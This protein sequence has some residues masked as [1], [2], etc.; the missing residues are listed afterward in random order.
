MKKERI[1]KIAILSAVFVIA[2][3]ISSYFV[4]RGNAG[5]ATDMSVA[6]LPTVSFDMNGHKVNELVG[7]KQEMSVA[8]VRDNIL[9]LGEKG[10]ITMNINHLEQKVVDVTYEVFSLDGKEEILK[11]DVGQT[12][13]S[14]KLNLKNALGKDAERILKI[15]LRQGKTEIY[16]YTRLVEDKGFHVKECVNYAKQFHEN[17]I[18]K[19]GEDDVRKVLESNET[20]DNTTLSHV[21]LHSNFKHVMWGD[22]RPQ[23]LDTPV[24]EVLEATKSYTCVQL[25]YRV[26][27]AGDNNEEEVY[28]VK[29]FF[30]IAYGKERMYLLEYDRKIEE[31]FQTSNV[32]LGKNGILLG[33]A[34]GNIPFKVNEEGTIISFVQANELWSYHEKENKF[35]L[36]FSFA[37]AEK[38]D[39]RH[40]T[41][42]HSIR[43]LSMEDNGNMT[44][45]VNGYMNRGVH[46]A[47]TGIA[48]YYYNMEQNVIEE[49]AFIS[50]NQS[51]AVIEKDLGRLA[52]YNKDQDVLY[53]MT[54]GTLLKISEKKEEREVLLE[55]LLEHNYVASDNGQMFA[56][57]KGKDN[58]SKAEIWDFGTD[59]R[60]LVE[61][62]EGEKIKPLGFLGDDFVYGFFRE[63][64]E[65]QDTAGKKVYAM[66]RL[67]IRDS[68]GKV[69]KTYEKENAYI[70]GAVIEGNMITLHQGV[71]EG[72]R[73]KE[74]AEDYIT[75]HESSS[76]KAVSLQSYWTDLKETQYLFA[77]AEELQNDKTKT[78]KPKQ[79]MKE[80]ETVVEGGNV[81]K[82][83]FYVYG[84]GEQAGAFEDAGDALSL[85]ASVSG[86]VITP[87]QNRIWETGNKAAWYRNFEINRFTPRSGDSTLVACIRQ[88]L[89][90]EGKSTDVDMD[91]RHKTPE[92]ILEKQLGKEAVRFGGCSAKDMRY[93]IDKGVPVIGLKNGTQAILLIGY[94]AETVTYVEPSSGSIFMSTFE[95]VDQLTSGSGH[96]YIGYMK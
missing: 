47:E 71:K 24:L 11:T 67:E 26:Q 3:F 77:F 15:T 31:E 28:V 50:S 81:E 83:Y 92:Q 84:C 49:K 16:Y 23:V 91:L 13:E 62:K 4:N 74:I 19:K 5:M 43:I 37:E 89:A 85:A 10:T 32:V 2:I 70:L 8:A 82:D 86:T 39:S 55:G 1:V 57:Q 61:S 63:G 78:L 35:A 69:V 22:L 51:L 41:D 33:I 95:K 80:K 66:H 60:I 58:F 20:G 6:T 75:N 17:V 18:Q 9:V 29:E 52:Y 38:E 44:F 96:T 56:Y 21:T 25:R 94:D 48:I 34:D 45:S 93:L 42:K 59:K 7:H 90:Y 54:E 79:V 76:N 14:V 36:I 68:Q 87:E 27:C 30:K 46:E 53:V 64:N 65:G 73:Y 40:R 12:K 72:D 88:V